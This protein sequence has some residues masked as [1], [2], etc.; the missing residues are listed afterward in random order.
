MARHRT[1]LPELLDPASGG[2]NMAVARQSRPQVGF[3]AAMP[4]KCAG[5]RTL[6]AASLPSPNGDPQAAI[7]AASPPLDPPGVRVKSYG[8]LVRPKI[9]LSLS[10]A[11][12][13][14]GRLV[15]AI[16]APPAARSRAT[17]AAS[18]RGGRPIAIPDACP[19]C[20][21]RACDFDRILHRE[22]TETGT[23]RAAGSTSTTAFSAGL[24]SAMRSRWRRISSS[25]VISPSRISFDWATAER[26]RIS[27]IV[28]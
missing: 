16:G 17:S 27:F 25:E 10:K 4:Q 19:P 26:V 2:R 5:R 7:S 21:D 11:N 3:S 1:D 18:S 20:S 24:I 13:R 22:R 15:R 9:R 23:V 6:P 14:S 8:L 28:P 12:S